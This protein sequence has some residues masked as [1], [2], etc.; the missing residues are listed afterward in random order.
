[1]AGD[2]K[3]KT[4][5]TPKTPRYVCSGE[6]HADLP[7]LQVA[8]LSVVYAGTFV[9]LKSLVSRGVLCNV[10]LLLPGQIPQIS[11]RSLKTVESEFG[12]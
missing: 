5:K 1:M 12:I 9:K 2:L 4:Q 11:A 10:H 3:K 7:A 6:A 8:V